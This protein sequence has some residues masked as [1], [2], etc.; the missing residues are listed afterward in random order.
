MSNNIPGKILFISHES[1][2]SGAPILLLNLLKLLS[3]TRNTQLSIVIK[4]GGRLDEFFMG[5]GELLV[6][7]SENYQKNKSFLG[8]VVDFIGYRIRLRRFRKMA[9]KSDCVI[10]NTITNGRLLKLIEGY[11]VPVITY[12]HELKEVMHYCDRNGDTSFSL[13]LS[14]AFFSPSKA[15][16]DNLIQ[17]FG[18]KD[19]FIFPLHYYFE[20]ITQKNSSSKLKAKA[21]AFKELNFPPDCFT[22]VGM[23]SGSYRKGTDLFIDIAGAAISEDPNIRF[24]WI[25]DFI[26]EE[27][28]AAVNDKIL[29]F[30]LEDKVTITGFLPS[31]PDNLMP[32]D[33]LALTSREDP[34]PLVVLEAAFLNI[35]SICF[36]GS[37]GMTEFISDDAGIIV[38]EGSVDEF[39]KAI[40]TLKNNRLLLEEKGAKA[41]EKAMQLHA[42][43]E[44]ILDQFDTG[45]NAIIKDNKR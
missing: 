2:I 27:I 28:K 7:K 6:L 11:G 17:N 4:R 23:G 16:T 10:S 36:E 34:Y 41:R 14:S 12:V 35:P 1:S 32:Y 18:I 8:K 42:N 21:K 3:R 40:L 29:A 5:F 19:T 30:N 31:S 38:S 45:I 24:V 43:A 44:I 15:V 26:E 37:G 13:R 9:S 22:V 39:V 25:G 33:L 20:S